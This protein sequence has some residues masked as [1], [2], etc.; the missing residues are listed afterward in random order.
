MS[1]ELVSN[2]HKSQENT[3]GELL[4]SSSWA[5]FLGFP[6]NSTWC[7]NNWWASKCLLSAKNKE[8]NK[9]LWAD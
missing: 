8:K 6:N 3:E 1:L 7:F 9:Q 5:N 2:M 4:Q